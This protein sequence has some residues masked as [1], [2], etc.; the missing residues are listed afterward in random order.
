M[1]KSNGNIFNA[2]PKITRMNGIN[3]S[4]THESFVVLHQKTTTFSIDRCDTKSGS[5]IHSSQSCF[6]Q[7]QIILFRTMVEQTPLLQMHVELNEKSDA[8]NNGNG[9]D[10]NGNGHTSVNGNVDFF[11][12]DSPSYEILV[13]L[14]VCLPAAGAAFFL[15]SVSGG[16]F[17]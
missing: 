5:Q 12:E 8:P 9:L 14:L 2:N 4:T 17:D 16:R 7:S 11:M 3:K 15:L 1:A 13:R 6:D 10:G